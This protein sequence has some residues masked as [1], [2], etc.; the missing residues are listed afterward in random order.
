M[1]RK[2][3]WKQKKLSLRSTNVVIVEEQR[4]EELM[5]DDQTQ[6]NA[7]ESRVTSHIRG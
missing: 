1:R 6:G 2:I 5:L 7:Q 3:K 4:Q